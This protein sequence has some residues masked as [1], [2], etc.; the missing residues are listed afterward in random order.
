MFINGSGIPIPGT[1]LYVLFSNPCPLLETW[2]LI[3]G[4]HI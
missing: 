2:G 1:E 4:Q 3:C